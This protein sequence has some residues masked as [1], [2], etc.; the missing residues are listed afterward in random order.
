MKQALKGEIGDVRR[1]PHSFDGVEVLL[2][3]HPAGRVQ[4]GANLELVQLHISLLQGNVV[5]RQH[6][7][8]TANVYSLLVRLINSQTNLGIAP[9]A[10]I[11]VQV[12]V[13]WNKKMTSSLHRLKTNLPKQN[14]CEKLSGEFT[15]WTAGDD[16]SLQSWLGLLFFLLPSPFQVI[17]VALVWRRAGGEIQTL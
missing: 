9:C 1:A 2:K 4:P 11:G 13:S 12:H 10:G 14:P 17:V 6:K 8:Q 5:I 3:T 7:T 16:D 15:L